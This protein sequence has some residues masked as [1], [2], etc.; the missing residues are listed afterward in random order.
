MSLL[1]S[2]LLDIPGHT[3]ILDQLIELPF[4]GLPFVIRSNSPVVIAAVEGTLGYWRG[5]D[6]GLVAPGPPLRIDIVALPSELAASDERVRAEDFSFRANGDIVLAAAGVNMMVAHLA[7]G[8]AMAFVT[9]PLAADAQSLRVGVIERLALLLAGWRDRIPVKAGAVV[10]NGRAL[11]LVGA[12]PVAKSTLVYACVRR[13]FQI[14]ADEVVYVSLAN[15][16]RIWGSPGLIYLPREAVRF[17]SELADLAPQQSPTGKLVIDVAG[18][19]QD[20]VITHADGALVCL[21]ERGPGQSSR[22]EPI[23]PEDLVA[24]LNIPRDI[25]SSG[26]QRLIVGS[27]PLVA[28]ALLEHLSER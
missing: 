16:L 13:G 21:V 26:A 9:P 24:A 20:R 17:F 1:F 19:G 8:Q 22:V 7:Q 27:N 12:D 6:P 14:L 10:R 18:P 2:S 28:V 4:L 23:A 3:A 15:R 5:L 11:L 25:A